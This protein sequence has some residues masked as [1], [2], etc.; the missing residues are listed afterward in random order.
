MVKE[1]HVEQLARTLD[2]CL[3]EV[4]ADRAAPATDDDSGPRP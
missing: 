1:P 2:A 3:R 4:E